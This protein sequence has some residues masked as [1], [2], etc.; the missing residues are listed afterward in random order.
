M[1]SQFSQLSTAPCDFNEMQCCSHALTIVGGL[2]ISANYYLSGAYVLGFVS[3]VVCVCVC[4]CVG[5]YA[6]TCLRTDKCTG[7]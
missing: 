2:G 1:T 6:C 5:V 4:V 3:C 7:E